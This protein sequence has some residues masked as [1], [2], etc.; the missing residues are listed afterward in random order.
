MTVGTSG[1]VNTPDKIELIPLVCGITMYPYTGTDKERKEFMP[2]KRIKTGIALLPSAIKLCDKNRSLAKAGSRN[3]FV[4]KA[5]EFYSGYLN[6]DNNPEFYEEIYSSR[7]EAAVKKIGDT[8]VRSQFRLAVEMAKLSNLIAA[9]NDF[10]E[11]TLPSL[12]QKCIAECKEL[13]G[14]WSAEDIVRFQKRYE[15]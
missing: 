2:E 13:A 8:L 9:T 3:E 5:I 7:G 1:G 4:E 15:R 6:A 10:P 14:I 11:S 12:A